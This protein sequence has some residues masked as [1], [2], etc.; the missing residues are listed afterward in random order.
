LV[1]DAFHNDFTT[2]SEVQ[3]LAQPFFE[4]QTIRPYSPSLKVS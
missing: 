1:Q 2:R 4:E 3:E